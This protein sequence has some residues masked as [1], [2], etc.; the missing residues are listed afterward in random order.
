[1][2]QRALDQ[3]SFASVFHWR[4]NR[5]EK[6]K[7][8]KKPPGIYLTQSQTWDLI[9]NLAT[10]TSECTNQLFWSQSPQ[11]DQNSSLENL[12]SA[13]FTQTSMSAQTASVSESAENSSL[14]QFPPAPEWRVPSW[15][16][17]YTVFGVVSTNLILEGTPSVI[18]N[19]YLMPFFFI[20]LFQLLNLLIWYQITNQ[21]G[22]QGY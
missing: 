2:F 7:K 1:M 17:A 15:Q 19:L 12:P 16:A 11:A 4:E 5:E 9:H 21:K 8:K 14:I 22:F 18:K 10:C 20:S 3:H 13:G 6:K